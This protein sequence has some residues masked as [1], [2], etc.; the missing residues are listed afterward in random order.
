MKELTRRGLLAGSAALAVAVSMKASIAQTVQGTSQSPEVVEA[1][2]KEGELLIYSNNSA[3]NWKPVIDGFNAKYPG[4]NVQTLDM[5]A[6][7]VMERYLAEIATQSRTADLMVTNAGD[8]W[9]EFINRD[10][11]LPYV[12]SEDAAYPGDFKPAPGLYTS[13]ADPFCLIW[14]KMLLPEDKWPSTMAGFADLIGE[15]SAEWNSRVTSHP[16]HTHPLGLSINYALAERNGD[17]YWKWLETL[18]KAK[19]RFEQSGGPMAEKVISGEYVAGYFV[20]G[21]SFLPR[22]ANPV[23]GKILG[24]TFFKDG[25][26]I[27]LRG[28]A[29][30]KGAKNT[31]AARLMLDYVLSEEGQ[32]ALGRGGITPARPG[33]QPTEGIK[34]TYSSIVDAVGGEQNIVL[35]RIDPE[36]L[37]KRAAFVERWKKNFGIQ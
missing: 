35:V 30:P 28:I 6:R 25:Q 1:A 34:F 26:P 10:V 14:N 24:W 7:E 5:G 37:P 11:I 32:I 18:A 19:P 13:S 2:K 9:A 15:H 20:S 12:S 33:L 17:Q 36:L 29:I 31:A 4:I 21:A 27:V 8:A 3:Q 22:L 23:G 16:A